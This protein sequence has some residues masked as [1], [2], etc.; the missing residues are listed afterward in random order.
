M[1]VPATAAND[2][3]WLVGSRQIEERYL[4]GIAPRDREAIRR[5][6]EGQC[7]GAAGVLDRLGF[8]KRWPR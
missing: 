6:M 2:R 8:G 5:W 4:I 1:Q 3:Y 7:L